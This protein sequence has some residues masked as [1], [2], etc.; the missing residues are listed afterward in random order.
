MTE[1]KGD[2]MNCQYCGQPF[3]HPPR[4]GAKFCSGTC[5]TAAARFRTK[6][7]KAAITP[8]DPDKLRRAHVAISPVV[9]QRDMSVIDALRD[10]HIRIEYQLRLI[11]N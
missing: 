9:F 2:S 5:R 6:L 8:P 11:D 4:R 7:K 10:G 1:G 3:P